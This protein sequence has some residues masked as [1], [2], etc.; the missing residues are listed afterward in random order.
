MT[1]ETFPRAPASQPIPLSPCPGKGAATDTPVRFVPHRTHLRGRSLAFRLRTVSPPRLA[2]GRRAALGRAPRGGAG[3][4]DLELLGTEPPPG[5]W[6]CCQSSRAPPPVAAVSCFQEGHPEVDGSRAKTACEISQWADHPR[7]PP[8]AEK[9]GQV[10]GRGRK[11]TLRL[12]RNQS[13]WQRATWF[14]FEGTGDLCCSRWHIAR[15]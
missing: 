12:R 9:S 11:D 1:A 8:Q 2:Q 13:S 6:E 10:I 5:P 14:T 15:G 3:G 4:P 7:G